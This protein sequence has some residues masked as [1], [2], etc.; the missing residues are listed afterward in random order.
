MPNLSAWSACHCLGK[1]IKPSRWIFARRAEPKRRS[2]QWAGPEFT[3]RRVRARLPPEVDGG[4]WD[5]TRGNCLTQDR[6]SMLMGDYELVPVCSIAALFVLALVA[7]V[8]CNK[9]DIPE[10]VR[11]LAGWF[12]R[13]R[14]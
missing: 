6:W 14:P 13:P 3:S 2:K 11:S 12:R 8:R 7:L 10:I 5:E 9:A 4:S 1:S